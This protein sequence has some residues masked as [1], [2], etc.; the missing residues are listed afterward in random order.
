MW[1]KGWTWTDSVSLSSLSIIY[2]NDGKIQRQEAIQRMHASI[3]D[4][5]SA[6]RRSSLSPTTAEEGSPSS[7]ASPGVAAGSE[8]GSSPLAAADQQLLLEE[9]INMRG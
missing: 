2:L 5:I 4:E 8:R 7:S 1:R 3:Y 9:I 6:V